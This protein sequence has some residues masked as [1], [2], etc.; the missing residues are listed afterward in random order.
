MAAKIH[1]S[2]I[3]GVA[4]DNLTN[5]CYTISEDKYLKCTDITRGNLIAEVPVSASKL[6]ALVLDKDYKRAFI[7]NKANDVYIYDV[8]TVRSKFLVIL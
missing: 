3:M 6:T 4:I 2:R 7:T 1:S 5:I 8:S